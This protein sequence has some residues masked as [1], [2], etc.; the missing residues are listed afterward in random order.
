MAHGTSVATRYRRRISLLPQTVVLQPTSLCNLSCTYC[1]L[2]DRHLRNHMTVGVAA[3]VARSLTDMGGAPGRQIDL[4]WHAG[5]PL[6]LGVR[7]LT[8]LV[9]PFEVLRRQGRL[10]HYVQTNA[11]LIST[12]WCSFFDRYQFRIGVSIDGPASLNAQRVDRRGRAAFSRISGGIDRLR[13]AGIPFS[14]IAVV[15]SESI[16]DPEALLDFLAGLGC[17]TIGLNIEETEGANTSRQTPTLAQ[18][19][20]FWRQTI[21]WGRRNPAVFVRELSRL[22]D[23]L[24]L[25]RT[26][27]YAEWASQL[28]DPIPTVSAAG[29]VVLL[30]P[31]LSG[32][33][34]PDYDD[35][36]V[37][38][39]LRDA[40]RSMIDNAY[41][42]R[43]V[44]EFLDGLDRCEATCDFFEFCQG[45]QAGNR[46]FENGRL[47]TT[48]T[49]YCRVSRQA[50]VTALLDIIRKENAS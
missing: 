41:R 22:G 4:V 7:R 28:M 12:A 6:T 49:N 42:L 15:T 10:R 3:A 36:I 47:D 18:A 1:Y 38:N 39:V 35:F 33:P 30:S 8:A 43:Y 46:Y 13:E 45:A 24:H 14:V 27:R 2:P 44:R 25:L 9:E 40:L 23:Y 37:G 11:T 21:A 34:A 20:R 32:I 31:E 26:G 5:E 48:E 17:H 29:D 50:L 16:D 19:T